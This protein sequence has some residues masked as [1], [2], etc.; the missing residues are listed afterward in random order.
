MSQGYQDIPVTENVYDSLS[1]LLERDVTGATGSSG[2][3]FPQNINED[4]LGRLCLRTDLKALYYLESVDPDVKWTLLIDF[5]QPLATLAYVQENYQPKSDNLTSLSNL[6]INDNSI[7]YF[8]SST[9]MSTLP[10]N[11]FLRDLL[12]VNNAADTRTLL[13]LGS[14]ATVN[15]VTSSN[16]NSLIDNGALPISKFSFIPITAGEGYA[17]GDI[18]ESY[19]STVETGYL[20]LNQNKTI[21]SNSSGATNRGDDYN[22]LYLKL[23]GSPAVNY[24]TSS[25]QSTSKGSSA[26]ADWGA[27]KRMSLPVGTNYINPN[28]YYRIRYK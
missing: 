28:C 27:N 18:K 13:G 5:S 26:S 25:G 23:W 24:Y 11:N 6:P 22:A 12:N 21:G 16:V 2:T 1:K 15:E 9:S 17:I 19:S 8:N 14:M 10:L 20:P 7:P 3:S 4:M